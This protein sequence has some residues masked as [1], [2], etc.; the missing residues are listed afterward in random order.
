MSRLK[1]LSHID[2]EELCRDLLKAETGRRFSAFGPG[3]DGGI[4]GRHSKGDETTVLQC[5]H[6]IGSSFSNLKTSI[7]NELP[8]LEKLKPKRYILC[9]SFSL[10][11]GKSKE[12]ADILGDFLQSTDDIWGQE[13]IKEAIRRQPEVEKSHMKL[14]LSSTTV[15]ERILQSGLENYTKA[16]KEEILEDL[17]VYAPNP[18]FNE[19]TKKLENEKILIV[20]GP[21]GVGKTTLARMVAYHY[22]NDEWRFYA[23]TSLDDGFTKIDDS[24]KTIFFFDDF[25]GRIELNRQSLLQ[26]D[27]AL[28][29]FVKRVRKSKNTRFI[30]TTRAHIFEEARSISDHVDDRRLQL[31]KYLLD[32]GAYTRE[33]KAHILFNHLS[34]SELT[35]EHFRSLLSGDWLKRIIDH[36][37]YNPRIIASVSSDCLDLVEASNF[38]QFIYHALE[39]PDLVWSKPYKSLDI[40]SQNLL[41]AL[42]FGSQFGEKIEDLKTNFSALHRAVCKFYSQSTK[43]GDFETA[44]QSL[45][46]GFVSISG[47]SVSF[48]NPSVR[49]FLK[50][51]LIDQ[52]FLLLLPQ[53]SQRADWASS[54]WKHLKEVFNTH[55][56][57]MKTF[58]M[59]FKSFASQIE[60]TSSLRHTKSENGYD[61][62]SHND[63]SLSGRAELLLDWWEYTKEDYYL[64]RCLSVLGSKEIEL[65]SWSDGPSLPQ[66]HWRVSNF[67]NSNQ[68]SREGLIEAIEQQLVRV[69]TN[70][71]PIDELLSV[72]E[73]VQEFMSESIPNIISETIEEVVSYEF[74]ETDEVIS[75]LD[76]EQ[77]LSEHIEQLENLAKMTGHNPDLAILATSEKLIQYE[78]PDYDEYRASYS[79]PRESRQDEFSD[80]A[81]TSLFSN[82]VD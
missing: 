44:L 80:E 27:T 34:V 59:L 73:A 42:F 43:P 62:F 18:S 16:S 7:R 32:V 70:G 45:E 40:K 68:D 38:P 57:E 29:T 46:S 33:I 65:I 82:L 53:S 55:P 76:T 75:H 28:A 64:E 72:V 48:V 2:F 63:L 9:T 1:N 17:K 79:R 8:K 49:D 26:R 12:I 41:V 24:K 13:D 37:N 23:I 22:L 78:E 6:Y 74:T 52:E 61:T 60:K 25:L 69:L 21:P 4:D 14:W 77:Q 10:T 58:A 31:A 35:Q 71:L 56:D 81:M 47:T 51:Y 36:R 5:K 20:S 30:L 66:L 11:P 67:V 15:L 3:P 19:A 50:A 54:V 39:N